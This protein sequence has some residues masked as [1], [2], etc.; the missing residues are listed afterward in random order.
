MPSALGLVLVF[1]CFWRRWKTLPNGNPSSTCIVETSRWRA[2]M[3]C[4]TTSLPFGW[5]RWCW[6]QGNQIPLGDQMQ[7]TKRNH[8]FYYFYFIVSIPLVVP[9]GGGAWQGVKGLYGHS[10]YQQQGVRASGK[11]LRRAA[12]SKNCRKSCLWQ[13]WATRQCL[14]YMFLINYQTVSSSYYLTHCIALWSYH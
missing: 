6:K 14:S 9:V 4:G 11:K 7:G 8:R 1:G 3:T 12:P 10:I 2:N 13:G 5:Y